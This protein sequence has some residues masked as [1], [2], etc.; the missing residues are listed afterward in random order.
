MSAELDRLLQIL[1]DLDG[2]DLHIKGGSSHSVRVD[3]HLYGLEDEP[4]IS[5]E[6]ALVLAEGIMR[7]NIKKIFEEKN[8]ADFAYTV[9]NLGRFRINAF[10]Q[11]GSVALAIRRVQTSSST[12]EEL[13]LPDVIDELAEEQRGWSS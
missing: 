11:R 8:E 9:N 10:R 1:C 5:A 3:G 6:D 12:I 13:C 4:P 2:S 7:P